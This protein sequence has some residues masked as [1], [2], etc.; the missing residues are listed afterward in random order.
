LKTVKGDNEWIIKTQE[1]LN[2]ILLEKLCNQ[3]SNENKRQFSNN[4]KINLHMKKSNKFER[5]ESTT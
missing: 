5:T 4:F 1:E 2:E 3:N